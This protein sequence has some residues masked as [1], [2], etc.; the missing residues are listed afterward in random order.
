MIMSF[1]DCTENLGNYI[2]LKGLF[3]KI[4]WRNL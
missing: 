2:L 3:Q 4:V 1:F